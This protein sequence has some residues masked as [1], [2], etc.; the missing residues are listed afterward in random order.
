MELA[1]YLTAN[2]LKG[3]CCLLVAGS[4]GQ[5]EEPAAASELSVKEQVQVLIE[6]GLKPNAAIKLVAQNNQMKKQMVYKAYHEIDA[7]AE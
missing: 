6:E 3:E 7:P 4:C 2:T 5:E 1:D